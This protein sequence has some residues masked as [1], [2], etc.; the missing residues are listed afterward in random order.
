MG[1]SGWYREMVFSELS[2]STCWGIGRVDGPFYD[3]IFQEG[4]TVTQVCW[5]GG[6]G[7]IHGVRDD[8]FWQRATCL[9]MRDRNR[10]VGTC[11]LPGMSHS[12]WR[13]QEKWM[14]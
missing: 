1:K 14:V 8:I 2:H 12:G 10:D 11:C 6:I 9:W 4:T 7:R 3:G 5:R 13:R